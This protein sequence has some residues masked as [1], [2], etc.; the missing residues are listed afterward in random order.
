MQCSRVVPGWQ[1]AS[2]QGSDHDAV[3]VEIAL[4]RF[5]QSVRECRTQDKRIERTCSSR[6]L[7][8]AREQFMLPWTFQPM[9]ST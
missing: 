8:L 5:S 7:T 9:Y 4:I 2:R 6:L 3:I 1:A